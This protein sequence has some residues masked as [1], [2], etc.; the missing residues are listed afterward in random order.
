MR[1]PRAAFAVQ[2]CLRGVW[3]QPCASHDAEWWGWRPPIWARKCVFRTHAARPVASGAGTAIRSG[4]VGDEQQPAP[5]FGLLLLSWPHAAFALSQVPGRLW[6]R[7]AWPTPRVLS[8]AAPEC[9]LAFVLHQSAGFCCLCFYVLRRCVPASSCVCCRP[10]CIL[11]GAWPFLGHGGAGDAKP[12]PLG[13]AWPAGDAKPAGQG[14]FH[15]AGDAKPVG[16]ELFTPLTGDMLPDFS[17]RCRHA[18]RAGDGE[19]KQ[20]AERCRQGTC[21]GGARAGGCC[22]RGGGH[23]VAALQVPPHWGGCRDGSGRE[24]G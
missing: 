17:R 7:L 24:G 9:L 15:T 16:F 1:R 11:P 20:E 4:V 8:Y 12:A 6:P 19:E 3:V 13:A 5:D 23:G 18:R 21:A 10:C 14:W 22:A 2:L